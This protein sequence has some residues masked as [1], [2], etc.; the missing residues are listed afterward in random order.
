MQ[1]LLY[2]EHTTAAPNSLMSRQPRAKVALVLLLEKID[3]HEW[4]PLRMS[5]AEAEG[6]GEHY[7]T[8]GIGN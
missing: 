6:C 3:R 1:H 2:I 7:R 5:A 8:D 4:E